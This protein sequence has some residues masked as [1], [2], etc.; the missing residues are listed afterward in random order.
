MFVLGVGGLTWTL[1][2]NV[3]VGGG[4]G[5]GFDIYAGLSKNEEGN[6]FLLYV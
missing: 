1:P 5:G 6:F 2:Q 3:L 4:G